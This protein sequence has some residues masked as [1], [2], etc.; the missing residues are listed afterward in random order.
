MARIPQGQR[1]IFLCCEDIIQVAGVE[2]A[3]EPLF[4]LRRQR[5]R[6]VRGNGGRQVAKAFLQQHMQ[7]GS[8]GLQPPFFA[9]RLQ[10]LL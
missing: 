5:G 4:A 10:P 8:F 1:A 2:Q 6:D 9:P 7:A 3:A